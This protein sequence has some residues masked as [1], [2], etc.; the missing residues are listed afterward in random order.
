MDDVDSVAQEFK[1]NLLIAGGSAYPRDYDYSQFRRI[2]DKHNCLLL[3][4]MSHFNALVL[5]RLLN[6]PF[7]YADIVTFTTHKI[8][9]G[10]RAGIVVAK[11]PLMDAIDQAVFPGLQGGPHNNA[12]TG[13][14]AQLKECQSDMFVQ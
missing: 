2:A 6:N 5:T 3:V 11:K 12:I 4:D 8:L 10:P 14:A 1:P 9:R 7:E 13:I